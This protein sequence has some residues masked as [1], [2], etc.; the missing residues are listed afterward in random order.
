MPR[1]LVATLASWLPSPGD[2][3]SAGKTLVY[4]AGTGIPDSEGVTFAELDVP[5]HRLDP[6]HVPALN[7]ARLYFDRAHLNR[8][9]AVVFTTVVTPVLRAEL[10]AA[11]G[12]AAQP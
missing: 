9:G 8:E 10:A 3:W 4:P 6:E 1:A 5:F 12:A 7:R 2:G 11:E